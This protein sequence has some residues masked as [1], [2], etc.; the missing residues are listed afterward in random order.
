M[1]SIHAYLSTRPIVSMFRRESF[2]TSNG[3]A[4]GFTNGRLN[5]GNDGN[6]EKNCAGDKTSGQLA[7]CPKKRN[8]LV[9]K[10]ICLDDGFSH[11]F[12]QGIRSI[13]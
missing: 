5:L 8:M 6:I 12:P 7:I 2:P 4:L 1:I 3:A 10:S 11:T 9:C 13:V